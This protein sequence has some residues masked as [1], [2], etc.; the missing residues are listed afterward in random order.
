MELRREKETR[1]S[2]EN[3][4]LTLEK[5][6]KKKSDESECT[7]KKRMQKVCAYVKI[8]T[9]NLEKMKKTKSDGGSNTSVL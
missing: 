2:T 9:L 8:I 1:E 6:K 7:Q 3:G 5:V 4:K